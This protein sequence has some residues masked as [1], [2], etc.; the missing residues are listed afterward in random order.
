MLVGIGVQIPHW[1]PLHVRAISSVGARC[2]SWQPAVLVWGTITARILLDVLCNF[3]LHTAL[4]PVGICVHMAPWRPLQF[5]PTR[6]VS[7][8]RN[9]CSDD[10]LTLLQF[11]P[12]CC[13]GPP[14]NSRPC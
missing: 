6:R 9:S 7:A 1:V 11:L 4:A 5:P 2:N 13:I 10:P 3:C 8:H 14:W 12:T